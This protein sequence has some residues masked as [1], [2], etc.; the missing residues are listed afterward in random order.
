MILR[1][2]T[3][4]GIATTDLDFP[5]PMVRKSWLGCEV[6]DAVRRSTYDATG[7]EGDP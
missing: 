4:M 7:S 3:S 6:G 2:L 1:A 5:E